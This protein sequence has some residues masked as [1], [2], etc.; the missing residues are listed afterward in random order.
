MNLADAVAL[1]E[2]F[3]RIAPRKPDRP[4]IMEL[5]GYPHWETVCSNL[6][7]FFL[8][9]SSP[10]G[11]GSLCL[12]ALLDTAG[13]AGERPPL[14]DVA[15]EREART[16]AGNRLDLLVTSDSHVVA[17]E[18]KI[19]ASVNN[20][21]ADYA[22]LA[23]NRAS[24]GG[25]TVVKI[26]LAIFP[27]PAGNGHGFVRVSYED[28]FQLLRGRLGQQ[29][30]SADPQYY[31]YLTDFMTTIENLKRGTRMDPALLGF[32]REHVQ[33]VTKLL[34]AINT[35]QNE[36]QSKV[37]ALGDQIDLKNK[38]AVKQV[39]WKDPKKLEDYLA[40]EVDVSS[41]LEV[42]VDTII[43][44]AGWRIE[45][46]NRIAGA[47]PEELHD[48]LQK[49]R[50]PFKEIENGRLLHPKNFDYGA[51]IE[52][53]RSCLQPII[54]ALVSVSDHRAGAALSRPVAYS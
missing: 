51:P 21:L 12:D 28:F 34:N 31:T 53:V 17:I 7:A 4:T 19:L 46:V 37:R 18:N 54:E 44:P 24:K 13:Q 26:L 52:D 39:P 41:S 25:R 11:L 1:I 47:R 32:L 43:S 27:S 23:A 38:A 40:Y 15:V 3:R 29:G 5:S 36:R 6:L 45:F 30:E 22:A 16:N 20:P 49:L 2:A 9:P 50:I 42:A 48:L 33:D 8:D 14:S 35:F 10:H